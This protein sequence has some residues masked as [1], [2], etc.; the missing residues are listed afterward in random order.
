MNTSDRDNGQSDSSAHL[1]ELKL[2]IP[3]DIHRAFQRC[4]W[5]QINETGQT[6]LHL[7][8]EVILDFLIKH[9]C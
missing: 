6:Q 2:L 3:E 8:E 9:G 4:L 5:V 1:V 7:M